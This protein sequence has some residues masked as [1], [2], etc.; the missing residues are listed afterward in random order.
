MMI[1]SKTYTHIVGDGVI[2]NPAIGDGRPIPILL[3]DCSNSPQFKNLIQ[4][5]QNTPPG[6]VRA[7]WGYN[8]FNKRFVELELNF[9]K[10]VELKISIP[11]DLRKQSAI[12]DSIIQAKSVY[13]QASEPDKRLNNIITNQKI[14]IEIHPITKLPKWDSML[15][16]QITKKIE[17]DGVNKKSAKDA[18][19]QHLA[20]MREF[21]GQR[22]SQ[23][24]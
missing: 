17:Q 12:A 22:M 8:P 11:F 21:S 19:K 13:L 24:I 1:K 9:L 10:P 18:A 16:K 6:D 15:L 20:R 14:I 5:H 4:V 3:L 2:V 7:R 23:K